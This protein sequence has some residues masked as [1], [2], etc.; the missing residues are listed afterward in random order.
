[1][2]VR[3]IT[4][5]IQEIE[6]GIQ[7]QNKVCE[8]IMD[9]ADET[10][11]AC[12]DLLVDVGIFC[13][14]QHNKV[15][16]IVEESAGDIRIEQEDRGSLEARLKDMIR[17]YDFFEIAYITDA[18]GVQVTS[19]IVSERLKSS[20]IG[21]GYD[22]DWSEREWFF[23]VRDRVETYISGI[24]RSKAT[25]D[26]CITVSVPLFN[27]KDGFSGVLAVDVNFEDLLTV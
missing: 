23:Y 26:F 11:K 17:K 12:G 2:N 14:E 8:K 21:A 18:D 20:S 27:N 4:G 6:K 13:L 19:N 24:Y 25:D 10:K 7:E 3:K 22:I 9:I 5:D 1:M 16:G 15:K